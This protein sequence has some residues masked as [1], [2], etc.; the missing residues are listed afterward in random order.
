MHNL[1][2]EIQGKNRDRNSGPEP[3]MMFEIGRNFTV[4]RFCHASIDNFYVWQMCKSELGVMHPDSSQP[5]CWGSK[6]IGLQSCNKVWYPFSRSS[7]NSVG[8]LDGFDFER[9]YYMALSSLQTSRT[10]VMQQTLSKPRL[11]A[12]IWRTIEKHKTK[13]QIHPLWFIRDDFAWSPLIECQIHF[14]ADPCG[15]FEEKLF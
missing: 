3:K 9:Q 14:C 8:F 2:P 1:I 11:V 15:I 10:D 4:F 13:K 5:S 12:R 6:F 7:Q